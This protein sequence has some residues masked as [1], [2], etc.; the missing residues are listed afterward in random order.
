MADDDDGVDLHFVVDAAVDDALGND[1]VG[2]LN[3][4]AER[5]QHHVEDPV[6]AV[7]S[8]ETAVWPTSDEDDHAQGLIA[9]IQTARHAKVP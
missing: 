5:G 3:V 2:G 1:A 9:S 6:R 7:G 8:V 4:V